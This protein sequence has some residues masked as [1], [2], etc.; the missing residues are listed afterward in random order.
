MNLPKHLDY[1]DLKKLTIFIEKYSNLLSKYVTKIEEYYSTT[2]S[3]TLSKDLH[4]IQQEI[5]QNKLI[6]LFSIYINTNELSEQL[7]FTIN[8]LPVL[9]KIKNNGFNDIS[10]TEIAQLISYFP[11][12]PIN[13]LS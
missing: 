11:S 1:Q 5:C 4:Y 2:D 7:D 10:S 12:D 8:S 13:D 3:K 9:E 6:K